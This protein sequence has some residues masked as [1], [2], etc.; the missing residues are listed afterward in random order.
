MPFSAHFALLPTTAERPHKRTRWLR[1]LATLVASISLVV[2]MISGSAQADPAP[3]PPYNCLVN[4]LL[5]AT[6]SPCGYGTQAPDVVNS[7]QLDGYGYDGLFAATPEQKTALLALQDS[8]IADTIQ[9]RGLLPS[10][11][12]SVK[13]NARSELKVQMFSQISAALATAASGRNHD[14]QLLADWMLTVNHRMQV[15]QAVEAALQYMKWAGIDP[16][17][18]DELL[19]ADGTSDELRATMA[20]PPVKYN[21]TDRATATSGWCVYHSPDPFADTYLGYQ[22]TDCNIPCTNPAGCDTPTPLFEEFVAFGSAEG[23]SQVV[24]TPQVSQTAMS[25]A[26]AALAP[27]Y[28]TLPA[29]A[30]SLRHLLRLEGLAKSFAGVGETAAKAPTA[31][32]V[33][34]SA[35]DTGAETAATVAKTARIGLTAAETALKIAS[36]TFV[37]IDIIAAIALAVL[38]AYIVTINALLPTNLANLIT[39]R[40]SAAND[41]YTAAQQDAYLWLFLTST[42]PDAALEHCDNTLRFTT[43]NE[44]RSPCL[45]APPPPDPSPRQDPTF[46]IDASTTPT[47]T[48]TVASRGATVDSRVSG[49]WF[50]KRTTNPDGTH[51]DTQSFR[52]VYEDPAHF[53]HTISIYKDANGDPVFHDVHE[54]ADTEEASLD[55][56]ACVA[57]GHCSVTK[58]INYLDLQGNAHLATIM[59]AQEV[60]STDPQVTATASSYT[61]AESQPI[62]FTAHGV[63]PIGSAFTYAWKFSKD[64]SEVTTQCLLGVGYPACLYTDVISGPSVS[65]TFEGPGTYSVIVTATDTNHQTA[66]SRMSVSVVGISPTLQSD[67]EASNL[68][69]PPTTVTSGL[70]HTGVHDTYGFE[71]DWGDDTVEP[72][73]I[74]VGSRVENSPNHTVSITGPTT[75]TL[76]AS[77]T[78]SQPGD[79]TVTTSVLRWPL[80]DFIEAQTVT[81]V[82]IGPPTIR[83][84]GSPAV[85]KIHQTVTYEATVTGAGPNGTVTF[86][87][88]NGVLC[89]P[90]T[91]S[92]SLPHKAICTKIYQSVVSTTVHATFTGPGNVSLISGALRMD[93]FGDPT[94]TTLIAS[95][96]TPQVGEAVTYTGIVNEP[97]AIGTMTFKEGSTV[98]CPAAQVNNLGQATCTVT[99][100]ALGPHQITAFYNGD[101]VAEPS[102]STPLT[103][104]VSLLPTTTTLSGPSTGRATEGL[105][106]T[107]SVAASSPAG[108]VTVHEG[109]TSLC[110]NQQLHPAGSTHIAT[111]FLRDLSVGTHTL[112]ASYGG[113]SRT[114]PSESAPFTVT[115]SRSV[116]T[117][118]LTDSGPTSAPGQEVA[119]T[120]TVALSLDGLALGGLVD[121]VDGSTV[122]CA[123]VAVNANGNSATCTT[124]YATAG[125]HSVVARYLGDANSDPSESAAATVSVKFP[126]SITLDVTHS[127]ALPGQQL[128]Y[129]MVVSAPN[130][131]G[132]VTLTDNGVQICDLVLLSLPGQ[133][134]SACNITYP[135]EGTHT[136]AA[137]YAGDGSTSAS[138]SNTIT[139][140]VARA[141]TTTTL[142]TSSATPL[143]NAPVTYTATVDTG[144]GNPNPTGTISFSDGATIICPSVAVSTSTPHAATC[145]QTYPTVG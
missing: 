30:G 122:V 60:A 31:E 117:T 5:L 8:V 106:F 145:A 67:P 137:T 99:Y 48:L 83:L 42:T 111:C 89:G 121:F 43:S 23:M 86:T 139:V 93:V 24:S 46:L 131:T 39:Q 130:P 35:I 143:P 100:D 62:T 138:T 114:A 92:Q 9:A 76:V 3:P 64:A 57:D 25:F 140:T 144:T 129:S 56:D 133:F 53:E 88:E 85:P 50:V 59:P 33:V 96:T 102:S 12:D 87:D 1:R 79:Y 21:T 142:S 128:S 132:R 136:L 110:G 73:S 61:V 66:E 51:F 38:E 41:D 36:F 44:S 105:T 97:F 40:R 34:S 47:S 109:S 7:A 123:G 119:Y 71:T 18:F 91:I 112:I 37:V 11:Y 10:D 127:T 125:A 80:F 49:P 14:Q 115:I 28:I 113:D 104:T 22:R 65:H 13:A 17:A 95:S 63:S 19:A 103:V 82:H 78:Y 52:A 120:A 4:G 90:V 16:S 72:G 20:A 70:T 84:T 26:N 74:L 27:V 77:H 2:G 134:I 135:N 98:L 94:T 54:Y 45:N 126:T 55:F 6:Y 124:T 32:K 141:V 107:V 58:T 29:A 116:T 68:A 15:R 69:G 81:R 75:A 101:S 118:T 108:V